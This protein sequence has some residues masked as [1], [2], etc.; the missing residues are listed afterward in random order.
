MKRGTRAGVEDRWH[1]SPKRGEQVPWPSDHPGPGAWCTDP[2][3]GEPGI[4]ITTA[5][6][7]NGRRWLA[8]WVDHDGRERSKAFTRKAE[9]QHHVGEVTTQLT[10]GAYADPKRSAVKF[11]TVA[12]E[13]FR[14]K[15]TALQ[16]KTLAGYRSLLD[17]VVLP[18]WEITR[19][20]D[21]GHASVQAWVNWLRESPD[22]RHRPSKADSDD[23]DQPQGLS[24][25]RVV[26]AFQVVD[27]VLTYAIRAH[28]IA[29]NPADGV[30]LPRKESRRDKALTHQ[31]LR[32]LAEAAGELSTA[33]YVLGYGGMRYSELAALRV[34]DVD[35]QR[36]RLRISR[37]I[38]YVAGRGYIEGPP[39]T[40]AERSVPLSE[41]VMD[42]VADV[43]RDRDPAEFV[44]PGPDGTHMALDHFRWRFDKACA[45]AGLTD[46]T[47]KTLRHTAGSLALASGL[48]VM[49]A[50]KL[51]GHKK[52][53]TTMDVYAHEMPDGFDALTDAMDTA[54]RTAAAT[55]IRLGEG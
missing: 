26:Q 2:T 14:G 38:T 6:H 53:T 43:I 20:R 1:R 23:D 21:I 35:V 46:V 34:R 47:P 27:Q 48:P 8:R 29:A 52:S 31:Q 17:L 13:W 37:K 16:P 39:K 32:S 19:L 49:V 9:A 54:A 24:A 28:Y 18:K 4:L 44:F 41:F 33:I 50:Q 36:R 45:A 12:E 10:T 3:H 7:G 42:M 15:R 22:A 5:R 55:S 51:L 40:H 25:A 11:G 30:H